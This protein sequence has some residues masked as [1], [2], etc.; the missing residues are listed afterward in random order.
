[1]NFYG[2]W[3]SF[4]DELCQTSVSSVLN[5]ASKESSKYVRFYHQYFKRRRNELFHL[6]KRANTKKRSSEKKNSKACVKKKKSEVEELQ[7]EL[8]S[9]DCCLTSVSSDI[10]QKFS[11][12]SK[13]IERIIEV[14][15]GIV[16]DAGSRLFGPHQNFGRGTSS[17]SAR[18]LE[19]CEG[20][21]VERFPQSFGASKT[22]TFPSAY[23]DFCW[24]QSP[25]IPWNGGVR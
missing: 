3:K 21:V 5:D 23:D 15:R 2:F 24:I 14:M 25:S 22:T 13:D 4:P 11:Q 18:L 7:E 6:I 9:L 20:Y 10:E 1:L 16:S 17:N 8:S 19:F 12:L